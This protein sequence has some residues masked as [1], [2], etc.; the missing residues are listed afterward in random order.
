[1][2]TLFGGEAWDF[3]LTVGSNKKP[4]PTLNTSPANSFVQ[5]NQNP[6]L[7]IINHVL[8]G[9]MLKLKSQDVASMLGR[10]QHEWD[11]MIRKNRQLVTNK[12]VEFEK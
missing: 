9:F 3:V 7:M 4:N 10:C 2:A 8:M 12:L 6:T 1:M 11:S 5:N